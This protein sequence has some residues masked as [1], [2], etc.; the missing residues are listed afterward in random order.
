MKLHVNGALQS[1]FQQRVIPAESL[2]EQTVKVAVDKPRDQYRL[3]KCSAGGRRENRTLSGSPL[4]YW[5]EL[6]ER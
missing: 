2:V 6:Q 4:S 5:Q 1:Y 3:W